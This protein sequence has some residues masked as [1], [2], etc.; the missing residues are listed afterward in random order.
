MSNKLA[1]LGWPALSKKNAARVIKLV[2]PKPDQRDDCLREAAISVQWI[3]RRTAATQSAGERKE[4]LHQVAKNIAAVITSLNDLPTATQRELHPEAFQRSLDRTVALAEKVKVTPSGGKLGSRIDAAKKR[5][6]ADCALYILRA[7]GSR[8]P[9]LYRDGPYF[10]LAAL[11]FELATG[12]DGDVELACKARL[13]TKPSAR[14][15]EMFE[16][17]FEFDGEPKVFED[18]D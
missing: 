8:P 2:G 18:N 15:F 13:R 9:T 4:A 10:E 11:L 3:K 16:M 17:L 5:A 6:A 1:H 14:N 12:K 7:Y